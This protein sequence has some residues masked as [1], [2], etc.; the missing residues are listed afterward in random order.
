VKVGQL[1]LIVI[2]TFVVIT[3]QQ[4]I[5]GIGSASHGDLFTIRFVPEL[6]IDLHLYCQPGAR[7]TFVAKNHFPLL[8]F[9]YIALFIEII[10]RRTNAAGAAKEHVNTAGNR[11]CSGDGLKFQHVKHG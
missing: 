6:F 8:H 2:E 3:V 4:P 9:E 11:R 10:L 5:E 7:F 1:R